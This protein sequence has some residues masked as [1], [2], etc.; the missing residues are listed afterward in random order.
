MIENGKIVTYHTINDGQNGD[1]DSISGQ[2]WDPYTLIE[3]DSVVSLAS[4]VSNSVV[5]NLILVSVANYDNVVSSYNSS[6]IDQSA[7]NT[8]R[9]GAENN[10]YWLAILPLIGYLGFI[11]I[12]LRNKILK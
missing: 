4:D 12:K 1:Y 9:S 7:L 2:V 11:G 6:N 5:S 10:C 3:D 8:A